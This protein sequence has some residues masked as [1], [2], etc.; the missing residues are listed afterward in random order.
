MRD[1]LREVEA[2][3]R[4]LQC[5]LSEMLLAIQV[6]DVRYAEMDGEEVKP[7]TYELRHYATIR[8]K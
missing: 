4:H 7:V 2:N 6:L 5:L 3:I 8:R 1:K